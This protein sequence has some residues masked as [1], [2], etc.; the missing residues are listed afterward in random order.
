LVAIGADGLGEYPACRRG[1][2]DTFYPGPLRAHL[3]GN[4][5]DQRRCF[6]VTG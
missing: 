1:Q 2:M 3:G 4:S 6:L 5:R